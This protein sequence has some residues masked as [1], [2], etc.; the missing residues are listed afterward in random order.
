[1]LAFLVSIFFRSRAL[2]LDRKFEK[3][4]LY[5]SQV[6]KQI[7]NTAAKTEFGKQYEITADMKYSEFVSKVPIQKYEDFSPYI[8]RML[9]GG[10]NI[11][12][13]GKV[14][15]FSKSSGT[16]NAASKYLPVTSESIETCH[17]RGG[18]DLFTLFLRAYPKSKFLDGYMIGITGSISQNEFGIT[19][20]DI[21]ALI[22][23]TLP[24]WANMFRLPK[25]Q[26]ALGSNWDI[27]ADAIID[28]CGLSDVR[29]LSGVPTWISVLI[30]RL[31]KKYGSSA[32]P[33]L[34]VII[35]GGV[36]FGSYRS[37][38]DKLLSGRDIKYWQVYNASEG[39]FAVQDAIGRD[40][41]ALLIDNGVFYEFVP[42]EQYIEGNYE[43]AVPLEK[44]V[45]GTNY[46][47]II[48]T[49]SGL[50]RYAIGDTVRITSTAPYRIKITGRT[51]FFLNMFGEELMIDNAEDALAKVNTTQN[52]SINHYTVAPVAM[53]SGTAGYHRWYIE[54]ETEPGSVQNFA[55]ELDDELQKCNS[56]Y[57]AKRAGDVIMGQ[58]QIKILP[59][60]TIEKWFASKNKLGG[61]NKF[62]PMTQNTDLQTEIDSLL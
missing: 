44:T 21:S 52:F 22:A 26:T 1:M 23:S 29:G 47:L 43:A 17:H 13:P 10:E 49:N 51:K 5:Q 12:W 7:L 16:T 48:T 6:L 4:G 11:L 33:N 24:K 25:I 15:M 45:I 60:G 54:F 14:T 20:G 39:F 61:Q 59:K 27:K 28:E 57:K 55:K 56:D 58:L 37:Y 18:M 46:A 40:D 42:L 2:I 35:H 62:P 36:A 38:F 30:E 34:E 19:T 3:A 41:M 9:Q 53:N 31:Q 32:W 50:Y 8:E